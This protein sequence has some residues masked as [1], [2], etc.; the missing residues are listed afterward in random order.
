MQFLILQ[1]PS[2][3]FLTWCPGDVWREKVE[4]WTWRQEGQSQRRRCDDRT[5]VGLIW[6]G[7]KECGAASRSWKSQGVDS[8]LEPP[9][10]TQPLTLKPSDPFQTWDLQHCNIHWC[11]FAAKLV[12]VCY[13][14]NSRLIQCVLAVLQT[15]PFI[16][17]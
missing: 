11:C 9:G 7:A 14:S 17:F 10:G 5:E 4:A 2:P 1:H 16:S 3:S 12:V 6:P 13:S 15:L 8:P